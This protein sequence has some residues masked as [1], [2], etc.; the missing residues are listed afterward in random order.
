MNPR[1]SDAPADA[2]WFMP[3]EWWPHTRC[4]MTWPTQDETRHYGPL[5][6]V[7]KVVAAVARK[8]AEFESVSMIVSRYS[9]K[10]AA[11][12]CG[13]AIKI[14]SLAIDDSW[15]RDTCPTFLVNEKGQCA[16]IAWLFNGWGQKF[17]RYPKDFRPAE[18]VLERLKLPSFAAPLV[19]EGGNLCVD[20]EATL[21]ISK[22]AI[23]NRNRNPE[24]SCAE[25]EK[26]LRAYL[27]VDKVVWLP[28]NAADWVTD[29]H[30][31]AIACFCQ[32]GVVIAEITEDKND[33]EYEALF[34]CRRVLEEATDARGQKLKVLTLM[35]PREIPSDSEDF[36]SSY[37]NFYIA[38]G[39][40]IMPQ[41]GDER[42]D[43]AA[44]QVIVAAFPDR[45][46]VQL[47]INAIAEAGGG[48]H[49]ITQQQ[50]SGQKPA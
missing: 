17:Y 23:L 50:P 2:G 15:S 19:L 42:A 45:R 47:P 31:E 41:F 8:I 34:E 30:V 4:W 29:G 9:A 18:P 22:T 33:P 16:G 6:E 28:G 5:K 37:L 46:V 39:G 7:K 3:A 38:N 49:C 40:I 11:E 21:L 48:I 44:R 1:L 26:L 13:D 12:A 32:P 36:C 14:V 43:E 24:L 20:G 27:G 35:R 25:A 10:Q